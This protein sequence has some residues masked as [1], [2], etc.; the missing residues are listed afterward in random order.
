MSGQPK[1]LRSVALCHSP[2]WRFLTLAMLRELKRKYGTAVHVYVFSDQGLKFYAKHAEPGLI[3]SIQVCALISD[4]AQ[5]PFTGDRGALEAEARRI[6]QR[7]GVTYNEIMMTDRHIGRGFSLLAPNFPRSLQSE[8][9]DYSGVLQKFNADFAFWESEFR[10]KRLDTMIFPQKIPG[11]VAR[12]LGVPTRNLSRTRIGNLFHWAEN[13]EFIELP[14]LQAVMANVPRGQPPVELA[15]YSQYDTNRK[16][17]IANFGWLRA[18]RNSADWTVK[19]AMHRATGRS[20][21]YQ[22]WSSIRHYFGLPAQWREVRRL[23]LGTLADLQGSP[24]VFFAMQEEP[25]MSLSW[26]S[27]ESWPQIAYLWQIARDLPAGVKLAVKEHIYAIGRRPHGFYRHLTDFKNVVLLDPLLPGADVVRAAGAIAT[28]TST[29][30]FEGAWIGKPV[31]SLS[32]HSLYNF[33]DHVRLPDLE[34]GGMRAV[35]DDIFSGR[36]DLAKAAEDGARFH[37]ALAGVSFDIGSYNMNKPSSL[38]PERLDE[39]LKSFE[40]SFESASEPARE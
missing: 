40:A 14:R 22:W 39:M 19:F 7:Y 17:A 11:V 25:E 12:T 21:G 33:L 13:G 24:F 38:E 37:R 28:I 4:G 23:P 31:I 18:L 15:T 27:P 36:I 2:Q 32:R 20:S 16:I 9:T 26:Q 10:E 5:R 3:D 34:P 6:E 29:A 1:V 30:G 8:A 35:L